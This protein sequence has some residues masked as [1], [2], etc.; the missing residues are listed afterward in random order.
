V[1]RLQHGRRIDISLTISPVCDGAVRASSVR[2][3][4]CRDIT[5]RRSGRPEEL[6]CE[7]RITA[8][9]WFIA[10]LAHELRTLAR[11]GTG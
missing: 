9:G 8:Q 5:D 6:R 10:L 3:K 1:A 4:S 7:T 2:P 11:S